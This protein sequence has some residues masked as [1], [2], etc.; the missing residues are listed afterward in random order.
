[1]ERGLTLVEFSGFQLAGD[2]WHCIELYHFAADSPSNLLL[3]IDSKPVYELTLKTYPGEVAFDKS[4]VGC[5]EG[6]GRSLAG[7][8]T[9]VYF[10]EVSRRTLQQ[11]HGFLSHALKSAGMENLTEYL[12]SGKELR[13]SKSQSFFLL[14]KLWLQVNPKYTHRP[15]HFS[16]AKTPDLLNGIKRL[17][18]RIEIHHNTP[19]SDTLLANG[20]V[21][22]LLPLLYKAAKKSPNTSFTYL[23]LTQ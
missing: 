6:K 2:K 7:E 13:M 19:V 5:L 8:V 12:I 1:M 3:Y 17:V 20:G 9:A 22:L 14:E 18:G 23:P 21:K 10:L 4:A 16:A 15:T 11:V